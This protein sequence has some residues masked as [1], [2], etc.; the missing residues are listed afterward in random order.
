MTLKRIKGL[1]F[2]IEKVLDFEKDRDFSKNVEY[3]EF[4]KL[5]DFEKLCFFSV[6]CGPKQIFL[7]DSIKKDRL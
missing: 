3:I 4:M 6:C 5:I 7:I 1:D 2:S